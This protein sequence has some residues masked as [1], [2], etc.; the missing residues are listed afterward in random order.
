MGQSYRLLTL[1]PAPTRKQA[2]ARSLSLEHTHVHAHVHAHACVCA[3]W[4]QLTLGAQ[5]AGCTPCL[6]HTAHGHERERPPC[7]TNAQAATRTNVPY[8]FVSAVG[9]APD[10]EAPDRWQA[11]ELYT[12]AQKM[13]RGR[14]RA[15]AGKRAGGGERANTIYKR[16]KSGLPSGEH[17]WARESKGAACVVLH[18]DACDTDLNVHLQQESSGLD[19]NAENVLVRVVR[20]AGVHRVSPASVM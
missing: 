10:L 1:C 2:S 9:A 14:A 11:A 3:R 19:R 20:L 4:K 16:G 18:L 12:P 15:G 5:D 17:P 6:A 7:H 8:L 13:A